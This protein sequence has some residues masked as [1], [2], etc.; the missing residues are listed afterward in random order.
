M[1]E[2][3]QQSRSSS[4]LNPATHVECLEFIRA[5]IVEADRQTAQ[6]IKNVLAEVCN[7]GYADRA[8]IWAELTPIE[9]QQ[10]QSLLAPPPL[11]REAG[12]ENLRG[13]RLPVP[14]CGLRHRD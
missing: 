6:D 4:R 3:N 7:S 9:Q 11:A 13:S 10:F 8:A 2:S 1:L 12:Q 14:R 5:A